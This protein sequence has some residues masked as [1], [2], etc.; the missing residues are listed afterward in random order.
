MESPRDM[1]VPEDFWVGVA[2]FNQGDFYACHDTL[3]AIWMEAPEQDK[4]FYQGILQ[5]AV[6]LYHLGNGNW[7]GAVI[8][9]GEGLNRLHPYPEDYAGIDLEALITQGYDLLAILQQ[10][11]EQT[12]TQLVLTDPTSVAD[13][14]SAPSEQ[15]VGKTWVRSRPIIQKWGSLGE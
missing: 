14:I 11:D 3:E 15:A 8:L 5:I 6:S 10:L 12:Y 1:T 4:K 2:Q 9:M 13:R 7:R